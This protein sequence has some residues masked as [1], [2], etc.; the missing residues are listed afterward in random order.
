MSRI[1]AVHWRARCGWDARELQREIQ[2]HQAEQDRCKEVNSTRHVQQ[3]GQQTHR[4][5]Q[6]CVDDDLT[7]D[8]P[9]VRTRHRQHQNARARIVFAIEPRDRLKMRKLPDEQDGE[10]HHGLRL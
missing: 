2:I 7:R 6:P 10:Q 1:F 5:Q 4:E 3:G 8:R 9:S